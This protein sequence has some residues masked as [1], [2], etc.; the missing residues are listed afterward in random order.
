[1]SMQAGFLC[2]GPR[3]EECSCCGRGDGQTAFGVTMDEGTI[4][5]EGWAPAGKKQQAKNTAALRLL[6]TLG[7]PLKDAGEKPGQPSMVS[8]VACRACC[9][10]GIFI[11]GDT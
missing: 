4:A 7:C 6:L 10:Y 2:H 8:C 5:T 3:A 1:M 11:D 9:M